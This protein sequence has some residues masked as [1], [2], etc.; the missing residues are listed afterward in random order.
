MSFYIRIQSIYTSILTGEDSSI[1]SACLTRPTLADIGERVN[2]TNM[3]QN[4]CCLNISLLSVFKNDD[5]PKLML[6]LYES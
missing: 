1:Y 4:C 3:L 2:Y 6:M 5:I